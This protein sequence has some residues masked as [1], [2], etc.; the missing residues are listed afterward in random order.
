VNMGLYKTFRAGRLQPELRIDVAN[1]FNT[2]NWGMP[3]WTPFTA[4]NFMEFTPE[5]AGD[6]ATG[7]TG[8]P[9]ARKVNIGVR[10][11]F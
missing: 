10:V 9:G 11:Q 2:V 3:V 8:T 7:S 4:P 1:V 5:S 6:N